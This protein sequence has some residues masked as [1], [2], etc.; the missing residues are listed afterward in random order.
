MSPARIPRLEGRDGEWTV[1][2]LDFPVAACPHGH[3]RR[4]V[5]A[6]FNVAW[7]EDLG[8]KAPIW[9]RLRG[10]FPRRA[11]CPHCNTELQP[12]TSGTRGVTVCPTTEYQ[13]RAEISGPWSR[14]ASCDV[15]YLRPRQDFFS[16]AADALKQGDI[17]RF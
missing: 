2:L 9:A 15:L 12:P 8:Y 7:S 11:H 13:F 14:C 6:D 4:E 17:T 16:A 1:A 10:F 5:Y 3:Q